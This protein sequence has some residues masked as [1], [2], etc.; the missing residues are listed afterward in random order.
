ME[1][2]LLSAITCSLL[3]GCH[4][5]IPGLE[6][7][8]MGHQT[9]VPPPPTGVIGRTQRSSFSGDAPAPLDQSSMHRDSY[10]PAS[11]YWN[12]TRN[13]HA[14][15]NNQSSL[16]AEQGP[17][18]AALT[19]IERTQWRDSWNREAPGPMPTYAEFVAQGPDA[20]SQRGQPLTY[21]ERSGYTGLAA[22]RVRPRSF[23]ASPSRQE[24]SIP[25]ELAELQS[26][27]V[28]QASAASSSWEQRYE[29]MRR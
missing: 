1:R 21:P 17:T 10:G 4:A 26:G 23:A 12:A 16:V 28:R 13:D 20:A 3:V 18:T 25:A 29:D 7:L 11:E 14:L 8:S 24:V 22:P 15:A 27:S 19:P 2:L 9:R 5:P 6:S